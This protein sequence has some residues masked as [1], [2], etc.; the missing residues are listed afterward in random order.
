VE[1]VEILRFDADT[2]PAE[3]VRVAEL[4]N[5]RLCRF[6]TA[7]DV[8]GD[9]RKELVAAA[10]RAGLWLLQ[11]GED[12]NA[13]WEATLIDADSSGF[14]H[15][16]VLTDLDGDGTD[17]LYVASDDQGEVRRYDWTENGFAKQVIFQ[18]EVQG[19]AFTWNL[20]PVPVE[21]VP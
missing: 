15:A 20:M 5:E 11:P 6:L 2:D 7:G 3:G 10:F 13:E 14:E 16:S 18:R 21:L 9:G 17:E 1:P 8:D 4:P 12:P 19:S